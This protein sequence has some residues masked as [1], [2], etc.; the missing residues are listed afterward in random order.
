MAVENNVIH[1]LE[2]QFKKLKNL[3]YQNSESLVS[4]QSATD[5]S[6]IDDD[7]VD[8]VFVDPPFGANIMYSELNILSESWLKVFTNNSMEAIM[9]ITQGK[10]LLEYQGLMER[11]FAELFRVLKPNRWITI[12]FHNSKNSVWNAIQEAI[13]KAGFIIADVRTL[14]KEKKTINQFNARGCVDQDLV[15]SAYKPKDAL[16]RI[17]HNKTVSSDPVL[18]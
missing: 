4:T 11:S 3:H 15:I 16:R 12:E 18:L 14:N 6:Q 5:L 1:Q 9:N 17:F 7:S 13:N 10:G 2:F 8:Y